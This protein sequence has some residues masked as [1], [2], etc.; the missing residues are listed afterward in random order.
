MSKAKFVTELKG[1][2]STQKSPP[3]L[4]ICIVINILYYLKPFSKV[5]MMAEPLDNIGSDIERSSFLALKQ[6]LATLESGKN[7]PINIYPFLDKFCHVTSTNLHEFECLDVSFIWDSV[8]KLITVVIPPLREVFLGRISSSLDIPSWLNLISRCFHAQFLHPTQT[9]E[10]VMRLTL[11]NY[12]H[13]DD[14]EEDEN[15]DGDDDSELYDQKSPADRI[16]G[17]NAKVLYRAP[18]I[19]VFAVESTHLP[20]PLRFTDMFTR[21]SGKAKPPAAIKFPES[22]DASIYLNECNI[23]NSKNIPIDP[24]KPESEHE[25]TFELI[26]PKW[27]DLTSVVTLEGA[28]FD[29]V[30]AYYRS[31]DSE[32]SQ[33][34]LEGSGAHHEIVEKSKVI[35]AN[36][37]S[38]SSSRL[39]HPRLLIYTKRG[40]SAVLER[41]SSFVTKAGQ[42]RSLG[43]AT[44]ETAETPEHYDEAKHYY[45]EAIIF[46][47]TLRPIL[48]ERLTAL[49]LIERNQRAHCYETQADISLGRRRF[50]EACDLY[51][52]AMRSAVVNSPLYL[53]IREKE[54]YMMKI[55]SLEIANHLTEKGQDCLRTGCFI[56]G[57]EHFLQAMKLNPSY[58]HLQTI[59]NGIDQAITVQTSA[60]KVTEGNQAMKLGKYKQANQ[61]FQESIALIP[62]RQESLKSVLDSLITLMQGEEALIKQRAGLVALE[63]KKYILAID[64]IT[65]A[66]SLLPK[67]SILEHSFFLCDRAL[68]YFEMKEYN[69]AIEDCYSAIELKP[70]LAMGYLRLGA[71]QYELEEYDNAI[72]SYEKASRYDHT[73]QD[74]IKVKMRQV[75]TSKEILQRKQREL[76]RARIK[77]EEKKLLEE[78]RARDEI[79]KKNKQLKVELEKLEKSERLHMK[80]EDEYMKSYLLQLNSTL[81][82]KSTVSTTIDKGNKD[83]NN[84]NI[85]T[86]TTTTISTTNDKLKSKKEKE[87]SEKE[88]IKAQEREKARME[89]E[90]ERERIKAAKEAKIAEERKLK[91]EELQ[92]QREFTAEMERIKNLKKEIEHEK[93]L[94]R[95]KARLERE[96]VIAEREKARE[97][98]LAESKRLKEEASLK[99]AADDA[100]AAAA[101]A[102]AINT[103]SATTAVGTLIVDEQ[104]DLQPS[105]I[106]AVSPVAAAGGVISNSTIPSTATTANPAIIPAAIKVSIVKIDHNNISNTVLTENIP[107]EPSSPTAATTQSPTI[108]PGAKWSSILTPAPAAAAV[109]PTSTSSVPLS[110]ATSSFK[111]PTPANY[112]NPY[113][114]NNRNRGNTIPDSDFPP[115]GES[116]GADGSGKTGGYQSEMG[117]YQ[118]GASSAW[119]DHERA[120]LEATAERISVRDS[121]AP[122]TPGGKMPAAPASMNPGGP[123]SSSNYGPPLSEH[124]PS[125]RTINGAGP[126]SFP[127]Q[128]EVSPLMSKLGIGSTG[129]LGTAGRN[130]S[131]IGNGGSGSGLIQRT[132]LPTEND[133]N[134]INLLLSSPLEPLPA[135]PHPP[136]VPDFGL[137]LPP[138][139]SRIMGHNPGMAGSSSLLGGD[140]NT[141]NSLRS[142]DLNLN[143]DQ[144]L[145]RAL[146]GGFGTGL[147]SYSSLL[148]PSALSTDSSLLG[149]GNS[150]SLFSNNSSLFGNPGAG[151]GNGLG[152]SNLLGY[153]GGPSSGLLSSSSNSAFG[154]HTPLGAPSRSTSAVQNG[155][156]LSGYG[157]GMNNPA[158]R[159]TSSDL[160][161]ASRQSSGYGMDL[162][163]NSF[164][165]GL[166]PSDPLLGGN[167][168]LSSLLNYPNNGGGN[169]FGSLAGGS[170]SGDVFSGLG[171]QRSPAN[172]GLSGNSIPLSRGSSSSSP[173]LGGSPAGSGHLMSGLLS[174]PTPPLMNLGPSSYNGGM[175]GAPG[176]SLSSLLD[177]TGS[178]SPDAGNPGTSSSSAPY[179]IAE[180]T[181]VGIDSDVVPESYFPAVA[182]LR[183]YH[184]HMYRWAGNTHEWTDYAMHIP[185]EMYPAVYT[186]DLKQ[187]N[188]AVSDISRRTGCNMWKE[189]EFLRGVN[190]SFIVFHKGSDGQPTHQAMLAALELMSTLLRPWIAAG[191]TNTISNSNTSSNSNTI[192]SHINPSSSVLQSK[193]IGVADN[194]LNAV[195]QPNSSRVLAAVAATNSNN[196]NNNSNSSNT[197]PSEM[198]RKSKNYHG[199]K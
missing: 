194:F 199:H 146:S 137:G 130:V 2:E 109:T 144:S 67:E 63:D 46:D 77:E 159:G 97:E 131:N 167:N 195:V 117:S 114:V 182:W 147:D 51:K 154:Q 191:T 29:S 128:Q 27:Y 72:D 79:I 181:S 57:K 197:N 62:E 60:Q 17:F 30:E 12:I 170:G 121:S 108:Q 129:G 168:S 96:R 87:K 101:A 164:D 45:E 175:A 31:L 44:F 198:G 119:A 54:D 190:S 158:S 19:L 85:T 76:E 100:A 64:F 155:G 81:T 136:L 16:R 40:M 8:I 124:L 149:G 125:P 49:D 189:T 174:P 186:P 56:Q 123:M 135:S 192:P 75:N 138:T 105:S 65:E 50:K 134:D 70:D 55:I 33:Q 14:E 196:N 161:G 133:D 41:L 183:S 180:T 151:G 26:A 24:T 122:P 93:E 162:N 126:G 43:D 115:L 52:N 69:I 68:V 102:V 73:L 178:R 48:Q 118:Y 139:S 6:I 185:Q 112:N 58:I 172:F 10:E 20:L 116:T 103:A 82:S 163:M 156:G 179:G 153:L 157:G 74:Q 150:N 61:L 9:L 110:P 84:N 35:E 71:C 90:K 38:T 148:G 89:K 28:A 95:E 88:I 23:A 171:L 166:P 98:K 177:L 83:D 184:M 42:M 120:M 160:L 39:V 11:S 53:R 32:N 193:G 3:P 113:S 92:K 86:T 111:N 187:L 21:T 66:I 152:D 106:G 18:E 34:W 78:K 37:F 36:Y 99:K 7:D 188:M 132:H 80:N 104:K 141:M 165:L 1:K 140:L 145:D 91:E 169:E 13:D 173:F 4:N 107:M 143:L 176:Q 142:A 47:S 127:V 15:D 25:R 22:F 59:I 94:E 5:I